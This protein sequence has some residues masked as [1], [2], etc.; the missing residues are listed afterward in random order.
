MAMR[1]LLINLV[2]CAAL[3]LLALAGLEL[4]LRLTVPASSGGSIYRYTLETQRYKLMKANAA[5]VAWGKELKTNALGFRDQPVPAKRAGEFRIAVLGDSFTVSA[6]VDY[7]DMY[8]TLVRGR[9]QA[10]A[11]RASLVNLA[12][13]GYNIVQYELVLRELALGLEPDFVLIALFPANDF[14][15]D[16]YEENYRVASGKAPAEAPQPWYEALYVYRAYLRKVERK[17]AAWLDAPPPPRPG[18]AQAGW[19]RNAAAL[20]AIVSLARSRGIGVAA[21]ILPYT[22]DFEPQRKVFA[23][24]KGL[25]RELD[26]ACL[27]LLEPFMQ[28]EIPEGSLRLNALDAH[29]NERYNALVAEHLAPWLAAFVPQGR[30]F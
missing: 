25:C 26:L 18:A 10:L 2:V 16:T 9:L 22:L 8:T 14:E 12:V 30:L 24:V 5:V 20:S 13:G 29:P 1:T 6:G 21:V 15:L 27:D 28:Q 23:R 19:E 4:Y 11:P 3:G 7:R 17:L